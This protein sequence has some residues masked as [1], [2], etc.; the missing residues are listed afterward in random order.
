MFK[1]VKIEEI[2]Q[3]PA[4][5]FGKPRLLALEHEV[6]RRF[7]NKVIA[8]VGLC[9]AL[10]DWVSV[11][12]DR[13]VAQTGE[14]STRCVFRLVVFAPFEGEVVFARVGAS[15]ETGLFL[16]VG[17][18]DSIHVPQKRLPAVSVWD[19]KEK[20]WIWQPTTGEE[21]A[22]A[23]GGLE[24]SAGVGIALDSTN[25]DAHAVG[26][27]ADTGTDTGADAGADAAADAA[28]GTVAVG[29]DGA[30]VGADAPDVADGAAQKLY[31]DVTNESVF[32]VLEVQYDDRSAL[33]PSERDAG[34]Q[35]AVMM[36]IGTLQ[37]ENLADIQGLGDPLWWYEGDDFEEAAE[38]DAAVYADGDGVAATE[39]DEYFE[40]GDEV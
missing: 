35:T 15:H 32:R 34:N 33:P 2:V 27:G 37:D 9:V 16:E 6:N 18:F 12:E 23:D 26:S 39:E 29:T 20:V 31:M 19:A 11:G 22:G 10:W 17:F 5:L 38:E 7:A 25:T 40:E 4:R 14:A 28:T 13:L 24:S 30:Y 36:V 21:D 3:V 1:L 8:R